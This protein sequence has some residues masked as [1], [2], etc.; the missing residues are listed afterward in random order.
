MIMKIVS[1]VFLFFAF[2]HSSDSSEIDDKIAT[3]IEK[4]N[5][6]KNDL[7]DTQRLVYEE[8]IELLKSKSINDVTRE[9]VQFGKIYEIE[10]QEFR[11]HKKSNLFENTGLD[12]GVIPLIISQL[13]RDNNFDLDIKKQGILEQSR[14]TPDSRVH[15]IYVSLL[16]EE[17]EYTTAI[18][19]IKSMI[20]MYPKIEAF[21]FLLVDLLID[22]NSHRASEIIKDNNID[23]NDVLEKG[24]G[25]VPYDHKPLIEAIELT[26]NHVNLNPN[27]MAVYV[28]KFHSDVTFIDWDKMINLYEFFNAN[29]GR[30]DVVYRDYLKEKIEKNMIQ[31]KAMKRN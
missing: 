19:H 27:A 2:I 7:S 20:R 28:E 29:V 12:F 18:E 3:H 26:K 9:I 11:K 5:K 24:I 14:K 21:N 30:S 8:Y 25:I 15:E 22:F 4:Y 13:Y 17:N 6:M 10:E 16:K 31:F 23:I 1:I